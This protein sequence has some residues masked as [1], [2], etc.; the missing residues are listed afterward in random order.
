MFAV[1]IRQWPSAPASIPTHW[2]GAGSIDRYGG[3]F[4]GLLLTPIIAAGAWAFIRAVPFFQPGKFDL[5]LRCAF[6]FFS[7]AVL[8]IFIDAFSTIV[9]WINGVVLNMNYIL[10]PSLLLMYAALGNL[11]LRAVQKNRRDATTG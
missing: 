6:G 3:K 7:Y 4:E 11:V 1:A 5:S 10:W 2:N 9:L 8:L